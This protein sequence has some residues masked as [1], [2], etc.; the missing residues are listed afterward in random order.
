MHLE[1]TRSTAVVTT[2]MESRFVES[3]AGRP[4]EAWARK[5]LGSQPLV[6]SYEFTPE[7]VVVV[8]EQAGESRRQEVAWPEGDWLPP[9]ALERHLRERLAAGVEE[10]DLRTVDPLLGMEPVVTRWTLEARGETVVTLDETHV[11]SRW[12]QVPD[13]APQIVTIADLDAAGRLVKSVTP[14]MGLRMTAVLAARDRVLGTASA[15]PELLVRS[16]VLS[17]PIARPRAL[18]RAV[19]ELTLEDGELPQIPDVAAQR[20]EVVDGRLRLTV[21]MGSSPRLGD[22]D[23]AAYLRASTY[24]SH[25]QPRIRRLLSQAL[26]GR[27]GATTLERGEALRAFVNG[28]VVEKDLNTLL[29]TAT[30]VAETR[31]GDCTEHAVL[32][33]ALLRAAGIPARVVTGL[34][35]VERFAGASR[36]FGY[37]MWSQA[38]VDSRWIDLDATLEGTR[39]DA[40][41]IT[42]AT[43]TLDDEGTVARDVARL[44]AIMGKLRLEVVETGYEGPG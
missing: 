2:D 33:T 38:L 36:I 18:R 28:Y 15:A 1:L 22:V 32:L 17:T 3:R 8:S 25:D 14:M 39:F 31:A 16:F 9:A 12:R 7:A 35:Y 6:T 30:E 26:A 20:H 44:G 10:F 13:Y 37:H 23:P 29:A 24:I 21:E 27:D 40:A 4:I 11:T 5:T 43:S 41:H 19:Y 42:F 34:V